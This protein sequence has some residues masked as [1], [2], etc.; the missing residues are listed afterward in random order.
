LGL[1]AGIMP[2]TVE[3]LRASRQRE[4]AALAKAEQACGAEELPELQAEFDQRLLRSEEPA[5][6]AGGYL[7]RKDR[8]RTRECPSEIGA[9]LLT[10]QVLQA[11]LCVWLGL[12]PLTSHAVRQLISLQGSRSAVVR[13]AAQ[14]ALA[15]HPEETGQLR[16][17]LTQ[18]T[19]TGIQARLLEILR[20]LGS[21]RSLSFARRA[22][23]SHDELLQAAALRYLQ[24]F[25]KLSDLTPHRG[26]LEAASEFVK[27]VALKA[28]MGLMVG[29]QAALVK[30]LIECLGDL[31]P[32]KS[33]LAEQALFTHPGDVVAKALVECVAS[34]NALVR[35][36]ARRLLDRVEAGWPG[37]EVAA[38]GGVTAPVTGDDVLGQT[39][40]LSGE[41]PFQWGLPALPV[42]LPPRLDEY[43]DLL[44]EDDALTA[45]WDE[46]FATGV[47]P[48]H[49]LPDLHAR[50]T[51]GK[52]EAEAAIALGLDIIGSGVERY[53]ASFIHYHRLPVDDGVEQRVDRV[54][55]EV[56]RRCTP[57]AMDSLQAP[58][59]SNN[60]LFS[61]ALATSMR[62]ELAGPIF[63][64][65]FAELLKKALFDEFMGETTT[66]PTEDGSVFRRYVEREWDDLKRFPDDYYGYWVWPRLSLAEM[67]RYCSSRGAGKRY[68]LEI[69]SYL[70]YLATSLPAFRERTQEARAALGIALD[71]RLKAAARSIANEQR[72]DAGE[73]RQRSWD[74]VE[75]EIRGR[76]QQRFDK[77]VA[78]FD[79][80]WLP[81]HPIFPL[82][83]LPMAWEAVRRQYGGGT[84]LFP[85]SHVSFANL[86]EKSILQ[87]V[88]EERPKR[89]D[90]LIV[91]SLDAPF[92]DD[93][94]AEEPGL[95]REE[96]YEDRQRFLAQIADGEDVDEIVSDVL[97]H[98]PTTKLSTHP[99]DIMVDGRPV[100]CWD[101]QQAEDQLGHPRATLKRHSGPNGIRFVREGIYWYLPVEE[102]ERARVVLRTRSQWARE[103]KVCAQTVRNWM[104]DIPEDTDPLEMDRLLRERKKDTRGRKPQRKYK[105]AAH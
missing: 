17:R 84:E 102:L 52:T 93:D 14:A 3:T 98:R 7:R 37:G 19:D 99:Q 6:L 95:S 32:A 76:L 54:L 49:L 42:A 60:A 89:K 87:L 11:D 96:Q 50:A 53:L 29:P 58:N 73:G 104:N 88:R 15:S 2:A 91:G 97:R 51:S 83:T 57:A 38:A 100:Q 63:C 48:L 9:A 36:R 71:D 94:G 82:G 81:P 69:T 8:G 34:D 26:T 90:G 67:G 59:P 56:F 4:A 16:Q 77:A 75:E 47:S 13:A 62:G 78:T 74:H 43:Y 92:P 85:E 33:L 70:G 20:C 80:H 68:R 12:R 10:E 55:R 44:R 105:R 64:L 27:L 72:R 86:I 25:G 1:R 23:E 18:E 39:L 24:Q 40:M 22:L 65:T 103:L 41:A 30:S 101:I 46:W 61:E 31:S 79:V 5:Q 21:P 66:A 35:V 28:V 45:H